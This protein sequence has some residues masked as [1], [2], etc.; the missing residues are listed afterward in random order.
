MKRSAVVVLLVL[1]MAVPAAAQELQGTLKKMK[2]A[3]TI[4][5]GYRENSAP[6]SFV[7]SDGKPTGYSIDLCTRIVTEVQEALSLPQ[8][9]VRWAPVTVADRIDAVTSGRIDM[10]CGSTTVTL[11]RQERVDFSP[12]IFIDG[13]GLLV[14]TSSRIRSVSDLGDKKVAVIPGTSTEP[15][16]QAA[17]QKRLVRAQIVPVKDHDEGRAA[18]ESGKA[19]AYASDRVLLVGLLVGSKDPEKLT[20]VDEQFSYE[21]YGLML[22]RGDAAFR[23]VVNRALSRLYRSDEIVRIYEKWFRV[24]GRPSPALVLM[25]LL[26]AVPSKSAPTET[27]ESNM[28]TPT[29]QHPYVNVPETVSKEAQEFLRTLRDPALMPAFPDAG[30]LAGWKKV[31]AFAEAAGT[32]TSAPRLKRYEHTVGET[33]LGG[34]PVLDV[35]PKNWTD[36]GKVLVYTHG[37]A[38]VMSSAA[39]TLGRA[40]IAAHE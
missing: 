21:P 34:V 22:R 8:L 4:V 5:L 28:T 27:E 14:G 39:S 1:S 32:A 29:Q 19:D 26:N 16:L 37:G 10:E 11:S 17:L 6:F 33:S 36:N 24:L 25:Y 38:H 12:L 15:A 18:L 31:Q 9:K 3:G 23:H 2:T 13:G 20:L 40:V 7:G 30:D 35:R